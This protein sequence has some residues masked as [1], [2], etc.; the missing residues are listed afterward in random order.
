MELIKSICSA[1]RLWE[2]PEHTPRAVATRKTL[3]E[4]NRFSEFS[5]AFAV[6]QQMSLLTE[7]SLVDWKRELLSANSDTVAVL[8]PGNIPMVELQ[9][10]LAVVLSGHRYIGSVSSKSPYL[11]PAFLAEI[12]RSGA[13]PKATLLSQKD[14][15]N[16]CNRLI[17]SG[18]DDVIGEIQR[19]A[20]DIG[21]SSKQCWF[22]G[23]RIAVAVLD[24]RE[25]EDALVALAED[26]LM[27][28]G[29]GCRSVSI[30]FAPRR[31]SIDGVLDSF[32][33]HRVMF[34][35]HDLTSG[36]LK[37]QQALLAALKTPHAYSEDYQFLLSRG[38]PI[39]QGPCHIRWVQY[40][41][42]EEVTEWIDANKD[43]LQGVF[44]SERLHSKN[45]GW[46][47]LGTAQRPTL[48]WHPDNRSH[49]SFLRT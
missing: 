34:P 3:A 45:A 7:E 2:D 35:A 19:S 22:R 20:S 13:D 37:M 14:A 32:G 9:D 23:H 29:M 30:V 40:D 6:N 8:N 27:H 15:L 33:A 31:M 4:A 1:A 18:S 44:S 38:E 25:D 48:N 5:I 21:L 12:K 42:L 39:E 17:V 43:R 11:F 10:Y 49:S 46:E 26:A 41:A 16:A 28:E 47:P 24:G 36:P